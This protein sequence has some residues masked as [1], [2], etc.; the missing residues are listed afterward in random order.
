MVTANFANGAEMDHSDS[1]KNEMR[2]QERGYAKYADIAR[3]FGWKALADFYHQEH[4]DYI[5]GKP[6]NGLSEVDSRILRL[7][8]AAGAD[9]TPLVH[10]WG[11]HPVE[12]TRL[13]EQ[14]VAA[15]L[16]PSA[17]I[18]TQLERYRTLIPADK[19]KFQTHFTQVYPGMPPGDSPDYG[20]GWYHVRLEQW[21]EGAA[22]KARGA[23]DVLLA[24]YFP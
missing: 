18:R 16:G 20:P 23:V 1:T 10:F 11:S 13:E 21:D 7:S 22:S 24:R 3:L 2:Y 4:L 5:A 9:L 15:G 6:A 17:A 19:A 12:P 8:V 14:I